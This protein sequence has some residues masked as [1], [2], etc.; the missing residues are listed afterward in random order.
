MR[1]S[2]Y[3]G[4]V[5]AA[6]AYIEWDSIPS[7]LIRTRCI[8]STIQISSIVNMSLDDKRK[9]AGMEDVKYVE[10]AEEA[11]ATDADRAKAENALVRKIDIQL[12]PCIWVMYLLSYMDVRYTF[13]AFIR[14]P[15]ADGHASEPTS[16]TPKSQV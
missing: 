2:G 12:L 14:R 8:L 9:P 5:P 6:E 16:A 1:S 13:M 4:T 11:T 10:E 15:R 7:I 3:E